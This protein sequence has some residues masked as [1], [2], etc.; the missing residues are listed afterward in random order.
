MPLYWNLV[1]D[2][3][4][5]EMLLFRMICSAPL[6]A[7]L[8]TLRMDWAGTKMAFATWESRG[9]AALGAALLTVNAGG[10]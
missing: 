10:L 6:L 1:S 5:L 4:S 2:I 9:N 3:P 8:I 7:I